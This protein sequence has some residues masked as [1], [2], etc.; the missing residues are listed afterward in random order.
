MEWAVTAGIVGA[1]TIGFL[2]GADRL[3]L[4]TRGVRREV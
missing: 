4:F 1:A 2:I 3:P